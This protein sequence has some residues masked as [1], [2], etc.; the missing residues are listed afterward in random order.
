M[1]IQKLSKTS[2]VVIFAVIFV[3]V[4]GTLSLL[5]VLGLESYGS[6][7]A[8]FVA[9]VASLILTLILDRRRNQDVEL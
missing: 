2:A 5:S 9:G 1:S 8:G 3:V 4:F 7:V 6:L